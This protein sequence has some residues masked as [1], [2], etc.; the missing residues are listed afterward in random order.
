MDGVRIVGL[1]GSLAMNS[2]SLAALKAALDGAEEAGAEVQLFD[3]REMDLPM[4]LPDS[5]HVPEIARQLVDAVLQAHGMIWSSP[6][7]HGSISGSF[8]N[9]VDWLELLR[10]TQPPYLTDKIIGLICTAGGT[11]GLQAINTM[12]FVVRALRGWTVPLVIPISYAWQ[13]FEANGRTVKSDIYQQLIALGKEVV[14]AARQFA[15]EG[16]NEYA[17][18]MVSVDD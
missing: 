7:Y 15:D 18:F 9:A 8:K 2:K 17:Q 11:H 13:V 6:L 1:G 12:E 10:D 4:Y 14:R 16:V 3:I 5:S